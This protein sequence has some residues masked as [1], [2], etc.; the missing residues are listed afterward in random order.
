SAERL[1]GT[2]RYSA[3]QTL[4][5]YGTPGVAPTT[6][7]NLQT[8]QEAALAL[9]YRLTP[10]TNLVGG[11]GYQGVAFSASAFDAQESSSG[12]ATIDLTHQLNPEMTVGGGIRYSNGVTP[13]YATGPTP[14]SYIAD[15]FDGNYLDLLF[16][17]QPAS[18]HVI[19]ARL[20][21]TRTEHTQATQLDFTGLTGGIS[22]TYTPSER[23]SLFAS[24]TQNTG[25]GPS[26]FSPVVQTAGG[27]TPSTG[28]TGSSGSGTGGG[29]TGSTAGT[30]SGGPG[31]APVVLTDDNNRLNTTL[32]LSGTYQ[33]T[34]TISVN[35]NLSI[36]NGDLV[37]SAG[38]SGN[39]WTSTLGLGIAYVP[40]RSISLTCAIS[41]TL[42]NA[43]QNAQ[44]AD[45]A[46]SYRS[47]TTSCTG[48]FSFF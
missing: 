45:L 10:R 36:N 38:A 31:T 21:L 9:R 41:V 4:G 47:P 25:S 42:Q 48:T 5:D 26:L 20:S 23:L 29:S 14:G 27:G 3:S 13:R 6:E 19:R 17:W 12:V 43:S 22:W 35:G 18:V 37:D 40:T 7:R 1:S 15:R 16:S 2:L 44:S 33:A 28:G 39:A 46:S 34:R 30:G 11:I 8:N 24:L 32:T